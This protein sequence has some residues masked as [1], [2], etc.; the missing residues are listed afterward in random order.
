MPVHLKSIRVE[1]PRQ[2]GAVYLALSLWSG[3]GLE[4]LWAQLLPSGKEH[5]AWSKMAAV[6]VAARF[7]EPSRELQIA[8]DW[9][10]RTALCDLLQLGK[11]AVNKDRLYRSLDHLL[12]LKRELEGH[13]SKRCGVFRRGI[14][15]PFWG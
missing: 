1:R 12:A 14:R 15:T 3:L 6:P 13:Q 2:F 10:R 9:Y 7:C 4:E 8:E 5:F 11:E